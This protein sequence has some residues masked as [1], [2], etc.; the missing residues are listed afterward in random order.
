MLVTQTQKI[1]MLATNMFFAS[2]ITFLSSVA[3][4]YL[5]SWLP[6]RTQLMHGL[7]YIAVMGVVAGMAAVMWFVQEYR[8]RFERIYLLSALSSIVGG[9][10]A[11]GYYGLIRWHA[12]RAVEYLPLTLGLS[13]VLGLVGSVI[14]HRIRPNILRVQRS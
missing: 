11:G 9:W 13:V 5:S 3:V 12:E 6:E 7:G 14:L 4:M 8:T 10:L 1:V 2:V